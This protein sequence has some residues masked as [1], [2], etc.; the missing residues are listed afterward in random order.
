MSK[1]KHGSDKR[2]TQPFK[3]HRPKKKRPDSAGRMEALERFRS[4]IELSQDALLLVETHTGRLIDVTESAC[5]FSGIPREELLTMSL[6]HLVI[7]AAWKRIRRFFTYPHQRRKNNKIL[8][9]VLRKQPRSEIPVEI[10]LGMT[11]KKKET[12]A[13][14]MV[15]DISQQIET[16]KALRQSKARL[17]FVIENM[18]VMMEAFD[19][20]GNI[21]VWNK[22]SEAV[23]HYKAEE[24]VGNREAVSLLYPDECYRERMV[25]AWAKRGNNYRNWEWEITCKDGSKRTISWSNISDRLY[26]P[27]WSSWGIGV[28][29]TEHKRYENALRESEANLSITL[30]SIADAVIATDA[31]GLINRMNPVA[32]TLTGWSL[33]EA[34]GLPLMDVFYIV[35]E[36]TKEPVIDLIETFLSQDTT[37]DQPGRICLHSKDCVERIIAMSGAPIQA[38]DGDPR[39][40]V[41]VFRDI[42]EQHYLAEQLR[43]AQKLES[44]GQLA[45]GIAHDFNNLLGGI[46]GYTQLLQ[47]HIVSEEHSAYAQAVID[48]S[49]RAA[50]L[51]AQLLAFS[52]RVETSIVEVDLHKTI[53]GV[54]SLLEHTID[55]RI[56]IQRSID[57]TSLLTQGDPSQLQNAILNIAVNARD[58]MPCGGVLSFSTTTV[59]LD[60]EYCRNNSFRIEP[61]EYIEISISDTGEGMKK[62]TMD[63]IFEPFFTTKGIGKGTGLGL[64]AVYGTVKKHGGTIQVFSEPEKGTLVK[65]YLPLLKGPI[66]S[67]EN[68]EAETLHHGKG[69]ILLVDDESIIRKVVGRMLYELGYEVIC[70]ENGEDAVEQ[71]RG[72][73]PEIDLVILDMV[74]PKMNGQEAFM[75]MKKIDPNVKVIV[76]SGFTPDNQLEE[77][78]QDGVKASLPKPFKISGLS[79]K[80][81]EVLNTTH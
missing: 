45:G 77:M 29:V 5:A 48:T 8:R 2:P 72:S 58:A 14:V 19:E 54:I 81:A 13:L 17:R 24:I 64:S 70:A 42:T 27:G 31:Q 67:I 68:I 38:N 32:E 33:D 1:N 28:D 35:N 50:E 37:L 20:D 76:S 11:P 4:L 23:T 52:R 47:K 61:G 46:M 3:A 49:K 7:P 9:T 59:S 62:D 63:R 16:E 75:E 26:V 41:L 34:L 55:R 56:E 66:L 78:L 60:E 15:R 80:V 40:I 65:L 25:E 12:Y 44:I 21:I 53:R 79:E 71:F 74:M 6:Q 22:E 51:I 30:N 10:T 73:H 43:Q 57:D 39:G 36:E 18:P 69:R